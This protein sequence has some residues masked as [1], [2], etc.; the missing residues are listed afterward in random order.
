MCVGVCD[1][2]DG[3]WS[4]C[5][6]SSAATT[7]SNSMTVT[8]NKVSHHARRGP[9]LDDAV[10]VSGQAALDLLAR[11]LGSGSDGTDGH[12]AAAK[13]DL[14]NR[15]VALV[16]LLAAGEEG[17]SLLENDRGR[18][19]GLATIMLRHVQQ[20]PKPSSRHPCMS[21]SSVYH[22]RLRSSP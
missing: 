7:G 3:L 2:I 18:L 11:L 9:L 10:Q 6:Y 19:C 1:V 16:Q 13:D 20:H 17:A 4:L 22:S 8:A 14:V 12:I 21:A 5:M 15:G